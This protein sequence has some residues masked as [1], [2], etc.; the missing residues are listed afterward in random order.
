M[1]ALRGKW[2]IYGLRGGGGGGA[3]VE[4]TTYKWAI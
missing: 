4:A 1:G 2:M 3:F